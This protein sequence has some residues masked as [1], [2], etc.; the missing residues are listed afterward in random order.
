[1][2]AAELE[3]QEVDFGRYGSLLAARWWLPLGG[4]VAGLVLGA[5]LALGGGSVWKA[6]ALISLGQPFSPTGS[7]PV[8]S[9]ATNPRAVSEII[10]SESAIKEA[11]R[12]SGMRAGN[13][14]GH[15]SSGQVGAGT[16]AAA[17]R[18][19]TLIQL[20]V[21]GPK[22]VKVEKA[23]NALAQIV[24][25]RT[26]EKYVGTKISALKLQLGS[27]G[28]RITTQT[29]SVNALR[30]AADDHSLAPLDRLAI[31]TQLNGAVQLLGQLQ[32][33]KSTAQQQLALAENVESATVVSPAAAVKT[34]ARSRR[35]S[36]LVAGLI[37][38]IL[39]GL[40]AIAWEPLARRFRPRPS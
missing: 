26:T 14:R 21:Q 3:E 6:D 13:L 23:A 5:L 27:L 2:S 8:A 12:K 9:F 11:A 20:T 39:G 10:R 18:S 31:V 32:D 22:P 36:M 29:E 37:G 38:L 34:T 25:E 30:A 1:M 28:Q 24:I 40:A 15:V 7:A 17:A 33:Q 4:L 16:G 19:A 35:T